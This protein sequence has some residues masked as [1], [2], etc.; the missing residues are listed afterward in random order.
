MTPEAVHYSKAS[1]MHSARAKV[2][3]EAHAKHPER[4]VKK[5]PEAPKSPTAVWINKP[6]ENEEVS[7]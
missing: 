1:A 2:L 5:L 7:H 6:I 4:F 3:M